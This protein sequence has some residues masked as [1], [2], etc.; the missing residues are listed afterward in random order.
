STLVIG[1]QT[2][3]A[4]GYALGQKLVQLTAP[5]VPDVYQGTESWDRSLVDPDEVV[6]GRMFPDDLARAFQQRF[7]DHGVTLRTGRR[8]EQGH[9]HE[10]G[11]TLTLDD[12]LAGLTDVSWT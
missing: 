2:L 11:I 7:T 9:E 10:G 6:G 4:T 12:G 3:H 1:S 8:V 5:G